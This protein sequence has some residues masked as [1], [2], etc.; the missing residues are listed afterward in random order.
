LGFFFIQ[1]RPQNAHFKRYKKYA[2]RNRF[3]QS[4]VKTEC[5]SLWNKK[6]QA[7]V[8]IVITS[9]NYEKYIEQAIVSCSKQGDH[10]E[11]ICVDDCS[12]DTSVSVIQKNMHKIGI[13]MLLVKHTRNSG[14]PKARNSGLRFVRSEFMFTLDADNVILPNALPKLIKLAKT[15]DSVAVYGKLRKVDE[16]LTPLGGH[17]SNCPPLLGSIINKNKIDAMALFS[18]D[19][20]KEIG[21]YDEKME[22]SGQG[23]ED[24]E[25]WCR[26]LDARPLQVHFLKEEIGLYRTKADSMNSSTIPFHERNKRYIHNKLGI[27]VD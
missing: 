2:E 20:L 26:I 15:N 13:P 25:L 21:G 16:N 8:S 6:P 9:F 24:W 1:I 4:D 23:N 14:L 27:H 3:S 11:L 7:R 17:L 12:S 5:N 10:V 18:T 19:Y 22:V